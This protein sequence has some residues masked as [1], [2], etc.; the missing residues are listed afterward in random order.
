VTPQEI[1]D[2][3][4]Y[5]EKRLTARYDLASVGYLGLGAAYNE[6][7]YRVRARVFRRALRSLNLDLS[8]ARVLDVGSGTGFYVDRWQRAGV[9]DITASDITD[10]AVE[11]LGSA[12]PGVHAVRFDVGGVLD[13]ADR[14]PFDIVSAFDVLFHI[15]DDE[16]YRAAMRNLATLVRPGGYLMLSDNFLRAETKRTATQVSR[17]V[18]DITRALDDAGFDVVTRRPVFVLMNTPVDSTSRY[19]WWRWGRLTKR[20]QGNE[21][22]GAALGRLLTPIELALTA[23]LR[24]GPSTEIAVCRRR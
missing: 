23:G 19:L 7:L 11:R 16:R 21:R 8:T 13:L 18:A 24:E 2:P 4:D 10:V 1:T 9:R 12:F 3:R 6:A 5:W 20:V 14:G 17:S 22:A 15:V